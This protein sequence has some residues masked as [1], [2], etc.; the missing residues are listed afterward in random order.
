MVVMGKTGTWIDGGLRSGV[1]AARA[2]LLTRVNTVGQGHGRFAAEKYL[3][4][5]RIEP[6]A[7]YHARLPMLSLYFLTVFSSLIEQTRQWEMAY[8]Q[9]LDPR[10][11]ERLCLLEQHLNMSP[12][13]CSRNLGPIVE[14]EAMPR[15]FPQLGI[16]DVILPIFVPDDI[17]PPTVVRRRVH[18]RS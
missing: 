9:R 6:R 13:F 5:I 3:R 12:L 15:A 2:V 7:S 1:P 8:A 18:F 16:D 4:L 10:R 14:G 11:R 17:D